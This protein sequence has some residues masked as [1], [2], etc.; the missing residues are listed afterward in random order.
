MWTMQP[1]SGKVLYF[2]SVQESGP[3]FLQV[4]NETGQKHSSR[5]VKQWFG[6]FFDIFAPQLIL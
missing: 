6:I 4:K 5:E 3:G 1:Q 2:L